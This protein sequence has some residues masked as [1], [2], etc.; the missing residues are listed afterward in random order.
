M[1]RN[2]ISLDNC[3]KCSDCVTV[4]PVVTAHPAYPGP[5][6]LGPELER[7]RREGLPCDTEWVEYC[8]GCHR[9]DLAC[10]NQV[11][12]SG[13]IAA[14]KARHQKPFL[15]K[16]R[17]FWFARP[18]L[19]G[20]LLT[21]APRLTNLLL[22]LKPVRLLMSRFLKISAKRRFP[23]YVA[24]DLGPSQA[25]EAGAASV[26]FFPG[27]AIRYNQPDLGRKVV[28]LLQRNGVR[29]TIATSGCCGLPALAN[30]DEAEAKLRARAGIESLI[31]AV[32]SGTRIV[33]ACTSCGHMLKTGFADLLGDEGELAEKSRKI[34]E[35]TFD[36]GEFLMG[37]ADQGLLNEAFQPSSLRLAYHAPCHQTSQGIGRP[38]FHL[39]RRVPGLRIEDLD[40]GCCGMSGTFGFK[41]EKYPVS[42]AVGQRLFEGIRDADPQMV[43]TECATCRMQ[44]EHGSRVKAIHPA[45]LLLAAY[46]EQGQ[47]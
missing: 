46:S 18:G 45:E 35:S 32:S 19:L 31:E 3:L 21:I 5:K 17:D 36:L 14:A 24:P 6:H 30:G 16:M 47:S 2:D 42:M 23:A 26:L 4:C 20:S 38:W 29:T 33:T 39:L 41:E 28:Q 15:R 13:L 7:L 40:A 27:C 1:R 25:A 8:L 9:C 22:G 10:P 34:A 44:I 43:V 11:D 37:R 12:V